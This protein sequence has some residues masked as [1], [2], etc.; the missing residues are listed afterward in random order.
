MLQR[1]PD[2]VIPHAVKLLLGHHPKARVQVPCGGALQCFV[3]KS[4]VCNFAGRTLVEIVRSFL[5]PEDG[6]FAR[7]ASCP[8]RWWPGGRYNS[9]II[10]RLRR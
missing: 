10:D 5:V 9:A 7:L 6:G 2:T 1:F 3:G 4:R 8:L